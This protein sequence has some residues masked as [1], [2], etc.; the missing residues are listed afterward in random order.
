M[1]S[2]CTNTNACWQNM[3]TVVKSA[4][5]GTTSVAV[6]FY[7]VGGT[8][9]VEQGAFALTAPVLFDGLSVA[10]NGAVTVNGGSFTNQGNISML[11][12]ATLSVNASVLFNDPNALSMQSGCTLR[13]GGDLLGNT[14]NVDQWQ[15]A[16]TL[17]LT[18]GAHQLEAM[19]QDFGNVSAGYVKN[20]AYGLVSLDTG[21][22]VT[23]VDQSKNTASSAP[24]CVYANSIIV[25]PGSLLGLNGL[26][27]YARLTQIGG[28]VTGGNVSQ[29]PDEGGPVTLGSSTP[30]TIS[31]AGAL[32]EWTFFGRAG[33]SVTVTVDPGSGNVLPPPLNYAQVQLYD[34]ATNLLAR[35]SNSAPGQTVAL[36]SVPLSA[37]GTY[38]VLV[39][40]P[41]NQSGST[42][43]YLV[44]VWDTTPNASSLVLNQMASGRITTPYSV[45]QWN[46]TAN[47]DQQ[48]RFNLV[49]V[50]SPG[51]AF[52][53]N[54][55]NGWN[56]FSNL[57]LSS[58]LITLPYTGGYTLTAH[59][60]G[61][62]YGIA[63]AYDL[64]TTAQTNLALGST[65]TG[66]FAGSGQAQLLV[67]K[68]T[69]ATP[70][71][72]TLGNAGAGNV[73][74]LYV[75][76]GSPPTRG[77]YWTVKRS[78]SDVQIKGVKIAAAGWTDF[79]GKEFL[80]DG[81]LG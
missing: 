24:E 9:E 71:L 1:S 59:E 5:P 36:L 6:P 69:N 54:G 65:F 30:G 48:V 42:G 39:R 13:V 58:D 80:E 63:Y 27:L 45:D 7:N 3:G 22:Q 8:I 41:A 61:G 28:S 38:S 68:V 2:S 50:S 47:A 70:V 21:A 4:G 35:A 32:D 20:F 19:S 37:D 72:L 76:L 11:G 34:P 56:G 14:R 75:G 77:S 43:N 66:N 49:N 44:T 55:P 60:T 29:V 17:S 26:H 67:F 73:T 25:P 40:G 10:G 81:V 15:P 51:V 46:F 33:Q 18:A 74:A 57:V 12:G 52:D 31:A 16:G 64:V 78:C 23:L 79:S 62:G 53:L